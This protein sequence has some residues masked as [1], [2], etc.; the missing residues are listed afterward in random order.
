MKKTNFLFLLMMLCFGIGC[1]SKKEEFPISKR[2]WTPKDY[3]NVIRKLKYGYQPDEKLPA[4][5]D[6]NTRVVVE[7]LTDQ[8]NFKVVLTDS[9]L[10]LNYKNE[11]ASEFFN[12]WRDMNGVYDATNRKDQYV[13]EKEMIKV[14]H[15]GLQLQLYY[16]KLGND[17]ILQEADDPKSRNT[18]LS[19]RSNANTLIENF[20]IYLD[21]INRESYYTKEGLQLYVSGIDR[22]FKELVELYPK[23]D[24]SLML[25]KIELLLKKSKSD[26]IQSS[27][28]N[29]KLW[30]SK[31]QSV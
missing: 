19:V 21:E 30:I 16:F 17:Q 31:A 3:E 28:Q 22:Y 27:L 4:F 1:E 26:L 6:P 8:Q 23:G 12:R 14:W 15:F 11:V 25:K 24:Y 5:S 9:E 2:Y 13:Y 7:K 20:T 10:G 18:Q 29:L